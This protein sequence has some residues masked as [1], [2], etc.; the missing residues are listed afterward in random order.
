MRTFLGVAAGD[1]DSADELVVVSA[2]MSAK[3]RVERV[4]ARLILP[5]VRWR[6][7]ED[8][9]AWRTCCGENETTDRALR[10][11]ATNMR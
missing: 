11:D 2:V 9:I 6:S 5:F 10:L 3:R 7:W 4:D 8:R 1:V